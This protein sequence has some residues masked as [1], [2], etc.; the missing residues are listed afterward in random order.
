MHVKTGQS[1]TEDDVNRGQ[2]HLAPTVAVTLA[3][4]FVALLV[5]AVAQAESPGSLQLT[6]DFEGDDLG[7]P[8]AGISAVAGRAE[9]A[10][11]LGAS[12]GMRPTEAGRVDTKPHGIKLAAF[13]FDAVVGSDMTVTWKESALL[14]GDRHSMTLRHYGE[15]SGYIFTVSNVVLE[16]KRGTHHNE[17]A[18][19]R[20]TDDNH[21]ELLASAPLLGVPVRSFEAEAVDRQTSDGAV[22]T[23]LRLSVSDDGETFTPVLELVDDD[24][25]PAGGLEYVGGWEG[26]D[27]SRTVIDDVR[28]DFVPTP[29]V[30]VT[31][32]VDHQVLQRD[33]VGTAD[34]AVTGTYRLPPGHPSPAAIE[35]RWDGGTWSTLD[36]APTDGSFHGVL[37]GMSQGQGR[38]EVR[39][40]NDPG[41][42]ATRDLVGIGDVFVIAGQS[43]AAGFGKEGQVYSP[44][45]DRASMFSVGLRWQE[46]RDPVGGVEGSVWP[47]VASH[48]TV[49]QGVPVAFVPT[50]VGGTSITQWQP[51]DKYY[52]RMLGHVAAAG[53]GA[54][55]VLFWQGETDAVDGMS[56]STYGAWLDGFAAGVENDLGV[57]VVV[58]QIGEVATDGAN[59]DPIREAQRAAWEAG[60]NVLAGPTLYDVDLGDD[61][62]DDGTHF[63]SNDDLQVAAE[64]WWA[65]LDLHFFGGSDGRGPQL[66]SATRDATGTQVTATFSDAT[67]PIEPATG[68][69]GF[70]V[71]EGGATIDVISSTRTASDT[72][73]LDLAAALS[74]PATLSLGKGHTAAGKTAP[75]DSTGVRLPAESFVDVAIAS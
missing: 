11:D 14:G 13:A 31:A 51:G 1:E 68:L 23:D 63:R 38:L 22:V 35:A 57:P 49:D 7:Q 60:G 37:P 42:V 36:A 29:S 15:I 40:A 72:I 26:T 62:F 59:L 44:D 67:L 33:A 46:L 34:V 41:V 12:K 24:P 61:S 30:V 50:A 53:G 71:E 47:L 74:G 65:A 48:H 58:A 8:P 75:T 16:Q 27:P 52:E 10:L 32:P 66:V 5:P 54:R 6:Y 19:Y 55:A 73:V 18:I 70:L 45:D 21:I 20:A 69:D 2:R 43:N 25:L 4:L 9:V 3:A 17:V 39:F 56:E 64:R 28:V